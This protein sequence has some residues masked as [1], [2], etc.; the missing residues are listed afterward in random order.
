MIGPRGSDN[1]RQIS[2]VPSSSWLTFPITLLGST[3]QANTAQ[4]G[5]GVAVPS[6]AAGEP[7]ACYPPGKQVEL[8]TEL[9]HG[10]GAYPTCPLDL[11]EAVAPWLLSQDVQLVMLGFDER[12]AHRIE[13]GADLFLIP[14]RFEP[15]GL[16]QMYSMRYGTVPIVHATGGLADTA[17]SFAQAIDF[18]LLTFRRFPGTWRQIQRAG[19][20]ADFSWNRSAALYEKVYE[21]VLERWA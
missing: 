14:S 10:E 11:F 5:G 6:F 12:L 21:R 13:A 16:N 9:H 8:A 4:T 18:A 7:G 17:E 1:Q 15:C 2:S 3:V 19:M 20:S